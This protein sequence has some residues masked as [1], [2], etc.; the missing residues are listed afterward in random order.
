MEAIEH[1]PI[2]SLAQWGIPDHVFYAWVAMGIL[3]VASLAAT[4][5]LQ[6]VPH[7]LQ[8]FLEA[9][10]E[11]FL[12]LLDDVIGPHEG[13]KHLPLIVTLGLFILVSNLLGLVPGL[14]APTGNMY[15]TLPCAIIV[16]VYYHWVG[17]RKQGLGRY[18]KHFCG[19]V[20][21]LAPLMFPIELVSHLARVLSLSLRLFG[22]M[23]AGH[24][25]LGIIF[26]LTGFDG[27]FGW[28]LTGKL[29]GLLMGLPAGAL[30]VAFTTGFL[31]PLKILV[32][33]LQAFIFCM[34]SM[35][36][37]AGAVEDAE[38]H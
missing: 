12:G 4:R 8:N 3:I 14:I 28:A 32:A 20:P 23:F 16:F 15:T 6:L 25:L 22:N 7:G 17:I 13:R 26:L 37:I 29:A 21:A 18:L 33:F 2:L 36:Y 34:L 19:P 10:M 9:V 5:N 30:L 38:H 24:I 1:P 11:Q 35:L 27:L 31:L